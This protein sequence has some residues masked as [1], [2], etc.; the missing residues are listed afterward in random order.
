MTA[1]VPA[2]SDDA[3]RAMTVA[4]FATERGLVWHAE[5]DGHL[6]AG[7]R[8]AGQPKTY[9][10]WFARRLKEL[11]DAREATRQAYAAAVAS[12]EIQPPT[13]HDRLE[14]TAAGHPDNPSVQAARRLLEKKR[15]K[16]ASGDVIK[17]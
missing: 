5:V 10:R 3:P 7:L 11:Q 2:L 13:E 14:A 17:P 12:G 1:P 15:Q 6:H 16:Q 9:H 8:A 4:E